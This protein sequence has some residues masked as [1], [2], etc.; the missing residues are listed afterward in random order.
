MTAAGLLGSHS[1]LGD[2][3]QTLRTMQSGVKD[4]FRAFEGGQRTLLENFQFASQRLGAGLM[5]GLAGASARFTDVVATG[6]TQLSGDDKYLRQ[7]MQAKLE[8]PSGVL[9]GVTAGASAV[10]QGFKSAVTGL[11]MTPIDEARAQGILGAGKGLA[12]GVV[13]LITKPVGALMDAASISLAGLESEL[14]DKEESRRVRLPLYISPLGLIEPYSAVRAEGAF[15]IMTCKVMGELRDMQYLTHMGFRT[16]DGQK[17]VVYFILN[18]LIVEYVVGNSGT[19]AAGISGGSG[20]G[21]SV[22]M[23]NG[24]I[25]RRI[26]AARLVAVREI[27]EG[28]ELVLED[29]GAV[30][31]SAPPRIARELGSA[32]RFLIE[33]LRNSQNLL[34]LL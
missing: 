23:S 32:C 24:R 17:I 4:F 25:T 10:A 3:K 34:V 2:P 19:T 14:A 18:R 21:S 26:T 8:R 11:I 33:Y 12:L 13:G 1:L 6:I 31:L 15:F 27:A 5:G 29:S 28:V 9:E 20:G 16:S 22:G 30:V 7:R